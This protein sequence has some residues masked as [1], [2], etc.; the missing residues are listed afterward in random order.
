[1][2]NFRAFAPLEF[3]SISRLSLMRLL[4]FSAERKQEFTG[5][6][7]TP[8][9]QPSVSIRKPRIW[10]WSAGYRPW[11]RAPP[12]R[13]LALV[14]GVILNKRIS[15]ILRSQRLD[16]V[17]NH[18]E[19]KQSRKTLPVNMCGAFQAVYRIFSKFR[20]LCWLH[21]QEHAAISEN[22]AGQV[23]DQSHDK[24]ALHLVGVAFFKMPPIWYLLK[25][26]EFSKKT[27]LF[28]MSN[29]ILSI[30]WP[31]CICRCFV[32]ITFPIH[33][34]RTSFLSRKIC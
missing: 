27:L 16:G 6:K 21:I 2:A 31:P 23:V 4:F 26:I 32:A 12:F 33:W 34:V 25:K 22:K 3:A 28:S 15:S 24:N 17:N 5:R 29:A 18:S 9:D 1:M 19:R 20:R 8:S 14:N 30:V 13:A 11:P 10:R 7:V